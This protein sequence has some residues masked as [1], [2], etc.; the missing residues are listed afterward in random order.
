MSSSATSRINLR[1]TEQEHSTIRW[2]AETSGE[3]ITEFAMAAIRSEAER[4]CSSARSAS[5]AFLRRTDR[6]R[7]RRKLDPTPEN[8]KGRFRAPFLR[9]ADAIGFERVIAQS[10]RQM[11]ISELSSARHTSY[12]L[13]A[14]AE[15]VAGGLVVRI[16]GVGAFGPWHS[17]NASGIDGCIPRFVAGPPFREYVQAVCPARSNRNRELQAL[18]RRRRGRRSSVVDAMQTL[19]LH[20]GSQ[21]RNAQAA[22]ERWI[23]Q[24]L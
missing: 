1:V 17:E 23:E 10:A 24:G 15:C 3:T 4:R 5:T 14:L 22:F 18:R 9:R 2:L 19:R 11:G 7:V 16:P 8:L 21:N 20:I 12:F 13:E 6:S